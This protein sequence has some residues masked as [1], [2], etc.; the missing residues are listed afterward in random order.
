MS[1]AEWQNIAGFEKIF[2]L[3]I[4]T[5][6]YIKSEKSYLSPINIK[7]SWGLIQIFQEFSE[8]QIDFNWVLI[9]QVI[10]SI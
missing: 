10:I 7:K 2:N 6:V 4:F 5:I 9:W 8:Y 1:A 3:G